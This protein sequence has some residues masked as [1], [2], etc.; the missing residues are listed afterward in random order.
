MDDMRAS[1]SVQTSDGVVMIRWPRG[2]TTL[3]YDAVVRHHEDGRLSQGEAWL[4]IDRI[5]LASKAMAH[6]ALWRDV[7]EI[8][9]QP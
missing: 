3:A 8:S 9:G 2:K 7:I 6:T 5:T 4:L 1:A